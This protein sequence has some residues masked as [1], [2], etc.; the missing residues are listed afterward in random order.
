MA[1]AALEGMYYAG[2]LVIHHKVRTRKYYDLAERHITTSV[3]HS[4]E[5]NATEQDFFDWF[6]LR[7]IDSIGLLWNRPSDAWLG[8]Q[9]S[10][11]SGFKSK[12][13]NEAFSRLLTNHK[14]VEVTIENMT[15]PLYIRSENLPMLEGITK[16]DALSKPHVRILAPLDNLLWDRNLIKELFNFEYRWEVYKPAVD[17]QYGYYVL[18]VLYGDQLI[19]R[20]EPEKHHQNGKSVI[21]NWWWEK[22]L[23]IESSLELAVQE[24]MQRFGKYLI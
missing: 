13:R 6:V 4:P 22:D 18:P 12:E 11:G 8:I 17:R 21:K 1:R 23:H 20:F 3:L 19:A 24:G 2:E 7:R 9:P 10:I 14:I 5:P 16:Q 15:F